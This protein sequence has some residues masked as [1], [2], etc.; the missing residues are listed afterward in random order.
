MSQLKYDKY[1]KE[2]FEGDINSPSFLFYLK[3]LEAIEEFK[4]NVPLKWKRW[5]YKKMN[6]KKS[7]RQKD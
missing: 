2:G 6:K 3:L 5:N 4:Q 1:K 7:L